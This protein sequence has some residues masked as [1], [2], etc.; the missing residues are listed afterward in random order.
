MNDLPSPLITEVPVADADAGPYGITAGPDG[1]LWLTLAHGG[2]SCV[3]ARTASCASTPWT[4]PPAAR[5]SSRPGPTARCGSPGSKDHRIGRITTRRRRGSFAVPT[6]DGGPYGITAGP[7]G[8]LW[9]TEMNSRPH[10]PDHPRR[11]DHRVPAPRRR[12]RSRRRSR[13]GPD[14]ALWFTLN[15]AN[16]IG[17]IGRRRR[18]R[19][20]PAADPGRRSR[21]HHQRRRGRVVR[22]DRS[23]PDRPDLDGRRDRGVRAAR[24]RGQAARHRRGGAGRLLVHRMGRQPRRPHHPGRRDRRPRP[25]AAGVRAARHLRGPGR[26]A[27][28]GAGDRNRGPS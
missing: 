22:R 26:S 5:R 16:A 7:D 2:R 3:S 8:A 13:A 21:R 19:R 6:P 27:V 17:R 12:A 25:A 28:G 23:R 20:P 18:S 24:P 15:Q 1:A 11:G 4:R 9:F 14:G 10:R